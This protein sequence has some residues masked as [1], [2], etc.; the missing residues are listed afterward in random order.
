MPYPVAD[1]A[2]WARAL[3]SSVVRATA[4]AEVWGDN[5]LLGILRPTG[6]KVSVDAT[7]ATRRTCALT[8]ADDT[9]TLTPSGAEDLLAP[10]GNEVKLFRGVIY[11]DG[12]QQDVPLGVFVITDV[13]ADDG[14]EGVQIQLTG[15]DRSLRISRNR[16]TDPYVI[17]SGTNLAT[18]LVALLAD[19]WADVTTS[20]NTTAYTLPFAVYGADGGSESDPWKDAQDIAASAGFDLYFDPDG[21]ARMRP[22]PDLADIPVSAEF[23]EGVDAVILDISKRVTVEGLYNGVIATGE[24][25]ELTAPV[26][27]EAWDENPAS[28]TYRFGK[29]GAIPRFYSSPLIRTTT[30]AQSAARA[31]L[32]HALGATEQVSWSVIPD[33]T[34]EALDVVRVARARLGVDAE[35]IVDQFEVPMEATAPM[36]MSGRS[37]MW[38]S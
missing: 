38:A 12:T 33:P 15:S 3:R 22:L 8:L 5:D 35:F 26:R 16:W 18:G 29:L 13:E 21:A 31:M 34:V 14:T 20:F 7:R 36:S 11:D 9:G 17:T 2:A 19:R 30:Q 1:P 24:G 23:I 6:G 37:R 10:Y 27:G 32:S 25:S 28:P 4:R